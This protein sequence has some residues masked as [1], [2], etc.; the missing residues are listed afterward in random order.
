MARN[1]SFKARHYD[2]MQTLFVRMF[3]TIKI[4]R[5]ELI[6]D[7]ATY[8]SMSGREWGLDNDIKILTPPFELTKT[9]LEY[10]VPSGDR[11]RS[12][13]EWNTK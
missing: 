7:P 6:N 2:E 13:P 8:V 4:T 11:C 5:P 3:E 10:I 1:T 9:K 12:K